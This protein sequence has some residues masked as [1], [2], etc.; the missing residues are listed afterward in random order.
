M[1]PCYIP[2]H[3]GHRFNAGKHLRH[4]IYLPEA[5]KTPHVH[6]AATISEKKTMQ[7]SA[8]LSAETLPL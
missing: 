7:H 2:Q 3:A 5:E 4:R 8:V 1:L 6:K